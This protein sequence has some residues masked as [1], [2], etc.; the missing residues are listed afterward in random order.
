MFTDPTNSTSVNETVPPVSLT[1]P[2]IYGHMVC[3]ICH[4]LVPADTRLELAHREWHRT[5]ARCPER[6]PNFPDEP[7]CPCVRRDGHTGDHICDHQVTA[8]RS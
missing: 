5:S 3:P 4:A 7:G 1:W 6:V 8:H 2:A